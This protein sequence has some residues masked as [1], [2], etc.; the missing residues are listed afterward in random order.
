MCLYKQ[1]SDGI[2]MWFFKGE[3][4]TSIE[5]ISVCKWYGVSVHTTLQPSNGMESVYT[6]R[7]NHPMEWSQC[8]HNATTIQW[9]GVSVHTTLQPSN[10]MESVYTQRYNHPMVWSQCTHNAT[11]IQWY[12]VSVHTTLQPSNG[13]E[14]VHT[15]RYNHPMSRS[16]QNF[17]CHR[18]S[19]LEGQ[20][21]GL[22]TVHPLL[23]P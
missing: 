21:S 3:R 15:Q 2:W 11:T 19:W 18:T 22:A 9:Y 13:M 7:Y 20:V 10:G 4:Q 23:K 5:D 12:G 6:Q 14:S 8:T 1:F 17:L 16:T